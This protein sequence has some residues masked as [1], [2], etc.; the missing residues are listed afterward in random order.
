[1]TTMIRPSLEVFSSSRASR[2]ASQS[3]TFC[4]FCHVHLLWLPVRRNQ[5]SNVSFF[6]NFFPW[7]C[8]FFPVDLWFFFTWLCDCLWLIWFAFLLFGL[9]CTLGMPLMCLI[10][11]LKGWSTKSRNTQGYFLLYLFPCFFYWQ[12]VQVWSYQIQFQLF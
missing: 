1:M 10:Y 11:C 6:Y 9:R 2:V 3:S 7:I 12:I 5:L 4:S 8:L